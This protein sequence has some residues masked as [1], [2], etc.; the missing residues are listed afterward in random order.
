MSDLDNVTPHFRLATERWQDAPT[1]VNHYKAVN[2]C[3]VGGGHG[4][5]GSVKSF[6]ESVCLTILGEFGRPMPSA[7]PSTTELLV[8]ALKPL[9]LQNTRGASRIDKLLSAHNKMADALSEMR[10]AN[11]P[12]A[13]G[14]D[15]FLDALTAN[16]CRA[17]LITADTILALLLSAYEGKE[18]NLQYTREPYD[19]FAHLNDRIDRT[20]TMIGMVEDNEEGQLLLLTFRGPNGGDQVDIIVPPS[21]LLYALDRTAYVGFLDSSAAQTGPVSANAQDTVESGAAPMHATEPAP[22]TPEVVPAYNGPLSPMKDAF[23]RYLASLGVRVTELARGGAILSDSLLATAEQHMGLDW[24]ERESLQAGM[25]VALRR[26]L[27]QFGLASGFADETAS[28]LVS[29]LRIQ[30][31]GLGEAAVGGGSK[32]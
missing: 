22:P 2:D 9:G 25:K 29:W 11:D 31:V 10:N 16:E 27:I 1:L 8:E 12:L 32:A 19:R 20:V 23:D 26:T 5:I 6:I 15:G 7:E 17:F 14:R 30:A 21:K 3:Y 13:H 24:A 28:H 4:L 18:P